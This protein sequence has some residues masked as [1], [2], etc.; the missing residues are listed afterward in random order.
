MELIM[1]GLLSRVDSV[2]AGSAIAVFLLVL[3]G[4]LARSFSS[5]PSSLLFQRRSKLPPGPDGLPIVG[6]LLQVLKARRDPKIG[7][8]YVG[9]SP[10]CPMISLIAVCNSYRP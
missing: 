7:A 6:N 5:L 2:V 9:P 10:L 8:A 4:L 3:Y 1:S